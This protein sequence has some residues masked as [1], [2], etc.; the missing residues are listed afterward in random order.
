[1]E[2][3]K[4]VT[5]GYR[6]LGSCRAEKNRIRVVVCGGLYPKM[7]ASAGSEAAAI[8]SKVPK[9]SLSG[10]QPVE[11]TR[12]AGLRGAK[13]RPAGSDEPKRF[14]TRGC[15]HLVPAELKKIG[16]GPVACGGLTIEESGPPQ[17]GRLRPARLK[18]AEIMLGPQLG[19]AEARNICTTLAGCYSRR[20]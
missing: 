14:V 10:R 16:F 19:G 2:L 18:R 1:M 17:G 12:K 9:R 11:C 4:F 7:R 13:L 8:G 15:A 6:P 20:F 5:K 3:K